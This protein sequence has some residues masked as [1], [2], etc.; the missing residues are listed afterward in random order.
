MEI[1]FDKVIVGRVVGKLP[2]AHSMSVECVAYIKSEVTSF[3]DIHEDVTSLIALIA[4]HVV[5]DSLWI[6]SLIVF[7][8][9]LQGRT[10]FWISVHIEVSTLRETIL[11]PCTIV[12]ALRISKTECDGLYP[13]FRAHLFRLYLLVFSEMGEF[14]AHVEFSI[15]RQGDN[16]IISHWDGTIAINIKVQ[17]VRSVETHVSLFGMFF[18]RDK[19]RI[20]RV[21]FKCEECLSAS[22][23]TIAHSDF[24]HHAFAR[25]QIYID[26]VVLIHSP[27]LVGSIGCDSDE[28]V[29]LLRLVGDSKFDSTILRT[30]VF[31]KSGQDVITRVGSKRVDISI[32]RAYIHTFASTFFGQCHSSGGGIHLHFDISTK[33]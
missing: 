5:I 7:C 4:F 11:H 9:K 31:F 28:F 1:R 2:R 21:T 20:V 32:R 13:A 29:G 19:F 16:E 3:V 33:Y 27:S 12:V 18:R 17:G 26:G 22:G 14:Y 10:L 25:S 8:L 6:K 15:L 23:R 24:L 30:A